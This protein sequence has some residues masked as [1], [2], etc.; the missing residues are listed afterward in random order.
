MRACIDA[1]LHSSYSP[2]RINVFDNNSTDNVQQVM[3]RFGKRITFIKSNCNFGFGGG[4]NKIIQSV[5]LKDDDYYMALNP[6]AIVDARCIEMLVRSSQKHAAD[7]MTGKLY[8]N[9]QSKI[10]Y[11]VGHALFRDGYAINI[12]FGCKD[13]G[14]YNFSREVFGSPGAAA[15]YKGS[16]IRKLSL[17]GYFFNPA[18]FMYHEDVD[19]DWRAR[20]LGLRCWYEPIAIVEHPGG[21]LPPSLEGE[22]LANRYISTIQNAFLV[23]LIFYNIPIIV[24]HTLFRLCV[25][26]SI[27]ICMMQKIILT[28]PATLIL[29]MPAKIRRKQITWWFCWAKTEKSQQPAGFTARLLLFTKR[30]LRI[31]V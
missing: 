7:W 12:G 11:S 30:L 23:D 6:D 18:L 31:K 14:Q 16:T 5:K 8:K 22:V 2:V 28:L 24:F 15:L 3:Q 27:G 29:R 19:I 13:V 17:G 1:I 26:P 9:L 20:L 4:H 21:D 25:T 10:L